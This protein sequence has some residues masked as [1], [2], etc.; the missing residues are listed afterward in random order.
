MA[1]RE[2]SVTDAQAS[3]T[4]FSRP[5]LAWYDRHHRSLP[6]RTPPDETKLGVLP[7][8]YRV[9]L[10]E[11]M[12]Q[13]T[14]VG[15]V[16]RYFEAFTDAWPTVEALAT[17]ETDDVMKA[18][19]G[20]GYYSRAR[21]LKKCAETV[22]SEY[23]GRFPDTE[24]GL[25]TLPGIGDYTAAAIAA[26]AFNRPAAVVDGN[27]ERVITRLHA[28]ETPLP[29]AKPEIRARVAQALPHD[30]PGDFAQ[31][32]MDLG[33]TICT[34]RRPACVLCPIADGCTARREGTAERF[35]VK[36]PKMEKPTRCGAAFVAVRTD[37]AV[38]LRQRPPTGL[39]GGM[40]EVPGSH[41]TARQDGSTD[42]SAAP[43]PADWR[44]TGSIRHVFTHF[45][46]ELSVFRA[47]LHN[48]QPP[49]D[50]MPGDGW[51]SSPDT[52]PGEAL[53]T[54]M[55]KAIEAAIPGATKKPRK[56]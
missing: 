9:W 25:K 14:T 42:T 43:F 46:L 31:A 48:D 7:D 13:Q 50:Q 47:D 4:D 1:R 35:P 32:M 54:V 29:Q 38:L 2:A 18:W 30:R 16:K 21:N 22:A 55:K 44:E 20:L 28:I 41:W 10:S 52:L 34:P 56:G 49:G 5:L 15:A 17:A 3:S 24:A 53:P 6:W 37:G 26:I 40:T 51:W 45:A 12:L 19:A 33:A 36:A 39:L 23:G 11:V 27:I 8:P